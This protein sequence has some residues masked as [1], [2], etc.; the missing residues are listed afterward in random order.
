[1]FS[2]FTELE[3]SIEVYPVRISILERYEPGTVIRVWAWDSST[4]YWQKLWSGPPQCC[5]DSSIEQNL[6]LFTPRLEVCKFKTCTIR[7]EL[8]HSL[9]NYYTQ[10]EGV[11][12]FGT[13]ELIVPK[14]SMINA[15]PQSFNCDKTSEE[16]KSKSKNSD[17]HKVKFSECFPDSKLDL[18]SMSNLSA[19]YRKNDTHNLTPYNPDENSIEY[20]I[21]NFMHVICKSHSIYARYKIFVS[22]TVVTI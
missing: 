5:K 1:M 16:T 11:L 6:R 20:D 21:K 7:L 22:S 19:Q 10:F 2:T 17:L 3:F 15:I 12:L 18:E 14:N 8:N 13:N 9:T 4:K